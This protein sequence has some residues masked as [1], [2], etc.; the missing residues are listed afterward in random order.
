MYKYQ[1]Y[2]LI[3]LK[4]TAGGHINSHRCCVLPRSS[5]DSIWTLNPC[6]G[7]GVNWASKC[8]ALDH[9]VCR[10]RLLFEQ[11]SSFPTLHCHQNLITMSSPSQLLPSITSSLWFVASPSHTF[12]ICSVLCSFNNLYICWKCIIF[13]N[14]LPKALDGVFDERTRHFKQIYTLNTSKNLA[15]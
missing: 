13:A 7:P 1:P 12:M 6:Q 11:A 15:Y 3:F 4:R 14:L 8:Q 10:S 5:P 9:S 2:N